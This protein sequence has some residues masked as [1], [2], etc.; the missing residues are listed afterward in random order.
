MFDTKT[1]LP[2]N[3]NEE[4]KY[5]LILL[6]DGEINYLKNLK[7]TVILV[8]LIPQNRSDAFTPWMATNPKPSM[9]ENWMN[10]TFRYLS[11][12][13]RSYCV[14]TVLMKAKSPTEATH[15]ADWRR[16]TVCITLPLRVL[17]FH[18]AARFGIRN[19]LI[20]VRTIRYLIQK[21][22]FICKTARLRAVNTTIY[23]QTHRYFPPNFTNF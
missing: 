23:F 22:L 8:G 12:C 19:F 11:I 5:P 3:Y 17:Y 1:S 16:Y 18:S 10:I 15:L 2:N 14:S 4:I 21:H 7:D 13:F 20:I 6:N 9:P